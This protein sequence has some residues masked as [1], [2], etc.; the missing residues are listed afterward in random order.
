MAKAKSVG[1]ILYDF[2]EKSGLLKIWTLE[3]T[4]ES[5]EKISNL[6][7]FFKKIEEFSRTNEDKTVRDFVA[8]LNLELEAGEEGT[9]KNLLDE[10][11]ETIKI[12]T[13]HQA[14]GLEFPYVFIVNL[15]DKRFPSIERKD[16]IEIADELVKEIVPEGDYHLQEERRIFYVAMTRARDGLFL[17]SADDYGGTRKKKSSRFL[18]ETGFIREEKK[19]KKEKSAQQ[20]LDLGISVIDK[21][22][23]TVSKNI[24]LLPKKFSFTQI[25]AFKNCPKQYR[26]AHILGVPGR[27]K[28]TFSFGQSVHRTLKD[29]YQ[30]YQQANKIPTLDELLEIY[31]KNWIDDWYDSKEQEKE[32]KEIGCL[33]LTDFYKK[34][35]KNFGQPKFIEKAFN[36]KIGDYTI[37]GVI[38]RVDILEKKEHYDLVEII[39]YKTGRMPQKK[40][41]LGAEQLLIY[42]LAVKEV[43]H[44]LPQ[45]LTYYYFDENQ[46]I[47][48]DNFE[49]QLA[50]LKDRILA[51]IEEIFKSDFVATPNPWKCRNCDFKEICEDRQL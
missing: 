3:K 46:P 41:D 33:S 22:I 27:P 2:I 18:E 11:P 15:V 13:I 8:Q 38:D 17:T 48:I 25:T 23:I 5:I 32:R 12:M 36:L 14:K 24:E 34:H 49:D 21:P 50:G 43:L 42:A 40:A 19:E 28:F 30:Q 47:S 29:F 39:D 6:K 35:E 44:D 37:K 31:E 10:G 45:K 1:Q 51:T 26:Y 20:K 4:Q 7:T 16:P 9:L